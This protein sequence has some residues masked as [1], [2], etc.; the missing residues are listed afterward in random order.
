MFPEEKED[1]NVKYTIHY[2]ID[3]HSRYMQ[4]GMDAPDYYYEFI[5]NG[6]STVT[7]NPYNGET[8]CEDFWD[9]VDP[10]VD[11]SGWYHWHNEP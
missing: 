5:I 3:P 4:T 1:L 6:Y 8:L 7:M 9:G 10:V 11:E 2:G